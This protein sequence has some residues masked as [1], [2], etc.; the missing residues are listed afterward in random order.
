VYVGWQEVIDNQN[1]TD[2]N[3][4]WQAN[5]IARY[6]FTKKVSL[7]SRIE[8]FDDPQSV[9]IVPITNVNGFK[10]YSAGVCLNVKVMENALFRLESRHFFAP[11]NVFLDKNQIPTDKS[12]LGIASMTIW[13]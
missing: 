2:K 12:N 9:Q 5:V 7:S 4:W 11:D 13:F 6:G 3:R 8:Y 10:T 1:N